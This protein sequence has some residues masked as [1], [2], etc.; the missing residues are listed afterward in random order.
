[1]VNESIFV[2]KT[3]TILQ[4]ALT[5]QQRS[6]VVTARFHLPLNACDRDYE[7]YGVKAVIYERK[8][9]C[10][11]SEC[12]AV[13]S[14]R[15]IDIVAGLS[16][17]FLFAPV[18]LIVPIIIKLTSKGPVFFRQDR[19]GIYGKKFKV[20]KFRTMHQDNDSE[21]HQKFM[22]EFIRNSG[23]TQQS[24][25]T[26]PYKMTDDPRITGIGKF[27]RKTSLDELPQFF[28]VLI[29]DM[30]MVGPRPAIPYEVDEYDIW[31]KRR[32]FEVKPGIT[33]IWQIRGRSRTDFDNMV[34]MDIRYIKEWSPLLDILLILKTPFA[35]L[36]TKGAY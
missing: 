19:L 35:L 28:N 21:I 8:P 7:R 15:T 13:F 23:A 16:L 2:N 11:R 14:K 18:F 10:R 22:R 17:L 5:P 3:D 29:G 6:L 1:M 9:E 34:R 33:G 31:H 25:E 4:R 32:V 27:L 30:S 36:S 24:G 26:K 20:L 12:L